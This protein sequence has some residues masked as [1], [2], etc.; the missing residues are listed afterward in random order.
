MDLTR[1]DSIS[2]VYIY[3]HIAFVVTFPTISYVLLLFLFSLFCFFFIHI[4][5]H[6]FSQSVCTWLINRLFVECVPNNFVIPL[7]CQFLKHSP[8]HMKHGALWWIYTYKT[9]MYR[10]IVCCSIRYEIFSLSLFMRLLLH[11]AKPIFVCNRDFLSIFTKIPS[12]FS[13]LFCRENLYIILSFHH[14]IKRIR[15]LWTI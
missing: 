6:F 2:Y 9:S 11:Y 14:N 8:I 1:L 13:S 12:T 15:D 4:Q 5:F 3:I 7:A 10:Q